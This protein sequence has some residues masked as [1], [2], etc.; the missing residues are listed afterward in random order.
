MG[1]LIAKRLDNCQLYSELNYGYYWNEGIG[2][3][4]SMH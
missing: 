4:I 1:L 3:S 2:G